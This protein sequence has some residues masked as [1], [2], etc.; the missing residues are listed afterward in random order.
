M[1]SSVTPRFWTL[2]NVLRRAGKAY[3]PW[4]ENPSHPSLHFKKVGKLWS[5]RIDDNLRVLAEVREDVTYWLW[6]GDH[7][8]YEAMIKAGR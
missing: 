8:T 6:I 5:A 2:Y 1:K 7:S 3:A 4:Q